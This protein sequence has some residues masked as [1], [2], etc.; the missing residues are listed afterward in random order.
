MAK[1]K[2]DDDVFGA[3]MFDTS[4][5]VF[6]MPYRKKRNEVYLVAKSNSDFNLVKYY[7]ALKD[8]VQKIEDDLNIME[9]AEGEH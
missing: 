9:T 1:K 3:E 8:F 5:V 2:L 7:L 6:E 4:D